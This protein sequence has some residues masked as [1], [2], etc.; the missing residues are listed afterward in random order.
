MIQKTIQIGPIHAWLPAAMKLSLDLCGDQII[1]STSE[2]GFLKKDILHR[3][4]G[5]SLG[6]AQRIFSHLEP[7]SALILD[8]LFS[9]AVEKLTEINISGRSKWTREVTSLIS[10]LNGFLKYLSS[11][12][13][14][15]GVKALEHILL[16]HREGLLDLVELLTGSRYGYSY[17]QP[18][19]SHYDI[20]DG[21]VER[22]EAWARSYRDDYARIEA[23]FHWTHA[24][25]NRLKSLGRVL[26]D[27]KMGFVTHS[28]VES[29]QF[30]MVSD[31]ES[32]LLYALNQTIEISKDLEE[33]L[34]ERHLGTHQSDTLRNILQTKPKNNSVKVELET[35]RGT[36]SLNLTID[37]EVRVLEIKLETPSE[38]IVNT[39]SRALE[40]EQVEDVPLIL[41]SLNFLVTEID[42]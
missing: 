21:F 22:L 24:F 2:F 16:K 30:G 42:R 9:E 20:T 39:I 6:D 27:G 8:R 36:W 12:A 33:L 18:G 1:S 26:D 5:K 17:L 23:L 41:Q 34:G 10:E 25:H 11:F 19:G 13:D 15:L 40:D 37:A 14:R 38:Q 29:T 31:V 7:E 4:K 35:A 32:R 28:A 3:V